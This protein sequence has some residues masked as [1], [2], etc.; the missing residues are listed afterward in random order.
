VF[1]AE[2]RGRLQKANLCCGATDRVFVELHS[3][4]RKAFTEH[5]HGVR[6]M[7]WRRL[8]PADA[9]VTVTGKTALSSWFR[10]GCAKTRQKAL[11]DAMC[12]AHGYDRCSETGQDYE[13]EIGL[14]CATA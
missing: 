14:Y 5:V 12:A 2:R 7:D 13:I 3:F 10:Y 1:E 8:L 6:A 9:N 4:W 11:C